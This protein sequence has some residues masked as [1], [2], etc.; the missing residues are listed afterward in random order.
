[1]VTPEELGAS[2]HALEKMLDELIKDVASLRREVASIKRWQRARHDQY[3]SV[4]DERDVLQSELDAQNV[5]T[6]EALSKAR[7]AWRRVADRL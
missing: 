2:I 1:M 3:L 5:K 4:L 7:A 6:Q